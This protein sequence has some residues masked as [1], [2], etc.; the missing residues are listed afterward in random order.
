M[1]HKS[2]YFTKTCSR[3]CSGVKGYCRH[4]FRRGMKSAIGMTQTQINLSTNSNRRTLLYIGVAL[5]QRAQSLICYTL[6]VKYYPHCGDS[7]YDCDHATALL[8]S[9]VR[10]VISIACSHARRHYP[11][12]HRTRCIFG[13]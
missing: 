13:G 11:V 2:F 7:P 5:P 6:G 12:C 8:P 9:C 4:F 3:P 1:N 10:S